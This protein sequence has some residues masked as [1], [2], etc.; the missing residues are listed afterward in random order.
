MR[1]CWSKAS[2]VKR[3]ASD[4]CLHMVQLTH[5]TDVAS[6]RWSTLRISTPFFVQQIGDGRCGLNQAQHT[7]TRFLPRFRAQDSKPL[8][9]TCLISLNLSTYTRSWDPPSFASMLAFFC[10]FPKPN[11]NLHHV[12]LLYLKGTPQERCAWLTRGGRVNGGA[13]G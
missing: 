5:G 4:K 9:P 8:R 12:L 7:N 10:S 3:F 6:T 2:I 13:R 1:S 11:L